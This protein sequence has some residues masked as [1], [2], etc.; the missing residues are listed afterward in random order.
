MPKI[1]INGKSIECRE[2]IPVLQAAI[3]AGLAVPHYCYH[4]GL[5]VVA[6]CRLCLME[7][8]TP[9]PKTKKMEWS[10]K[11]VPS[12]QAPVRE[13]MEV[14]FDSPAVRNN[15]ERVMEYYLVNHPLDCPVC[16]KAGECHLQD[17]SLRFGTATSRMVDAKHKNP[18]KDIG[19]RTLLYQDRCILC[20]RCVRFT[21][22]IAG[23]GELGIVN[24]G[25]GA[26]I[27]VFPGVPLA[28]KLQGNVVDL[29]PVGSLL[30]KDFL[31]QQRVWFLEGTD[32]ICRG[33]GTGCAIRVDTNKSRIWRLRPRP[34]SGTND[35]WMCDEGRFGWRFVHDQRRI[36]R[37]WL[38]RGTQIEWPSWSD[39]PAIIRQRF[40][41]V[42]ARHGPSCV[43][44]Q[45][46]PEMA[47]EEAWL[48]ASFIR[49][50]TP[51]ATLALGDV[52]EAGQPERFP[53][54]CAPG[55][56]KFVIRPEKHPNRR[57]VE[58]ILDNLGGPVSPRDQVWSR[59]AQGQIRA[60]WIV[61]GY[62]HAEWAT[63]ELI[64]AAARLELLVVQ[65]I[66]PSK[67]TE[68]AHIVLPCCAWVEREG[69]FMNHAGRLQ[70]FERAL[71]PPE[72]A[73]ADGQYLWAVAGY[74]EPYS[75]R[76]VREM[77]AR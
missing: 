55:Q 16:D 9:N 52:H 13:G 45:L 58:M 4:P 21:D 20:S 56:E 35:W 63:K 70:S 1:I 5:S 71:T 51:E 76:R 30:D 27:D 39:L 19:P 60:L 65:D 2:G 59:A 50:L 25:D 23:T 29:C 46:S 11:L 69:T 31:F 18:K 74:E 48:L 72:G 8:K 22:E 49:Q 47:W 26:E 34:N 67:L 17:Y 68:A 54:G 61:G 77:T 10:P 53:V 32:S 41:A 57:G 36:T 37:P 62:P 24:R 38:R 42:V 12:C 3:E 43:A 7:M 75:A 66:F 6:S 40:Q 64:A 15:Q 14:R 33:C 28:N 44:A 73:M